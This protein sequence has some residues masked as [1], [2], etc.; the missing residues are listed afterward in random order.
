MLLSRLRMPCKTAVWRRWRRAQIMTDEE[1]TALLGELAQT[2]PADRTSYF[3]ALRTLSNKL[4]GAPE[5]TDNAMV[6][7]GS[8]SIGVTWTVP[9]KMLQ[10]SRDTG[11]P[12]AVVS[13]FRKIPTLLRGSAIGGAVKALYGVECTEV[14]QLSNDIT[15]MPFDQLA[16]SSTRDWLIKIH[17]E[18]GMMCSPQGFVPPPRAGLCR[19]GTIDKLTVDHNEDFTKAPPVSWF[20]ELDTAAAVLAL[21]PKA[22]PL[23]ASH[24]VYYEDP[25]IARLCELGHATQLSEIFQTIRLF[26]PA[27]VDQQSVTGLLTGY[28]GLKKPDQERVML[29]LHRIIRSRSQSM[30]GNRAIDLAIVLEV[31]FMRDSGAHIH[32]VSV[33]AARL[34]RQTLSE[35]RTV[36][37]QVKN[38]YDLRSTLVHGGSASKPY[39]VD[40]REVPPHELV[41]AVDVVCVE[42]IRKFV[43]GGGMPTRDGWRDSELS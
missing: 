14:I 31:L 30:P 26:S 18:P 16:A 24:W 23:E 32:K 37:E 13:W 6:R 2:D 34:V 3:A 11:D 1:L 17:D 10:A 39:K 20:R 7:T 12:A 33:R 38:L 19:A 9:Q 35:R 5:L 42:A 15:L 8:G 4:A 25:D 28:L 36:F 22:I 43:E 41:E 27:K 21:V 29:A 40:G